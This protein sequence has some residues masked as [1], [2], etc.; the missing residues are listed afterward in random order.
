MRTLG[1]RTVFT[2]HFQ[3]SDKTLHLVT[4]SLE[5]NGWQPYETSKKSYVEPSER[6]ITP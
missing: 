3:H 2:S 1:W 4:D 6:P 5:L